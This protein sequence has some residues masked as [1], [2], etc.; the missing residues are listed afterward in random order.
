MDSLMRG[1]PFLDWEYILERLNIMLSAKSDDPQ[2]IARAVEHLS[3]AM[4]G[5]AMDGMECW[6][7]IDKADE[8]DED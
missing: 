7:N 6:L 2:Q 4:T 3:R 5:M 1:F 8:Y